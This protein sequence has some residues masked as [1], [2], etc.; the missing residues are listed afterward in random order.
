LPAPLSQTGCAHP[1][2]HASKLQG[3]LL[4]DAKGVRTRLEREQARSLPG[5]K[6]QV[7]SNKFTRFGLLCLVP[8]RAPRPRSLEIPNAKRPSA[9]EISGSTFQKP[10]RTS[11]RAA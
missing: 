11:R 8:P 10:K 4:A 2:G 5:G 1:L 6:Y 7:T 3:R 9:K